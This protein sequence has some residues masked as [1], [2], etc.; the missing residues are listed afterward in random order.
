MASNFSTTDQEPK[1]NETNDAVEEKKTEKIETETVSV[2]A[3]VKTKTVIKFI[4]FMTYFK[5][6]KEFNGKDYLLRKRTQLDLT[7]SEM[8]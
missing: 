1:T 2:V 5:H 6:G 4:E 3:P 7:L 8:R